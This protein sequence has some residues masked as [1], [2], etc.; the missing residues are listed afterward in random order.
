LLSVTRL[1]LDDGVIRSST[2][3]GQD[4][5]VARSDIADDLR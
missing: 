5:A 3:N 4:V 1:R 2:W